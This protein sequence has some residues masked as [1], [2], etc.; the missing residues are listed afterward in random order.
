MKKKTKLRVFTRAGALPPLFRVQATQIVNQ[1]VL[2][3]Q[4]SHLELMSIGKATLIDYVSRLLFFLRWALSRN[5]NWTCCNELDTI[6]VMCYDELYDSDLTV[7]DGSKLLAAMKFIMPVLGLSQSVGFPRAH[8]ALR[9]WHLRRPPV[10]RIPLPWLGL[11]AVLGYL[12]FNSMIP[13]AL[14]LLL[15]FHTYIRPGVCDQLQVSQLVPPHRAAGADFSQWA[16]HLYPSD[17]LRPGKTGGFDEAVLIDQFPWLE[18]FLLLLTRGRNQTDLLWPIAEVIL[19]AQIQQALRYLGLSHLNAS[20]Y[21][22]RHGGASHYLLIHARPLVEVQS[23]GHW[24]SN[25]SLARYGKPARALKE[26]H[27]MPPQVVEYGKAVAENLADVFHQRRLL[28][29]PAGNSTLPL[30][31]S[32]NLPLDADSVTT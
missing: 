22:L 12:C 32:A 31:A 18:P 24:R 13:A 15:Q 16:I 3:K 1:G 4:L 11:T 10:Q 25:L 23:R 7:S 29:P 17:L 21:A 26:L 6:L 14:A 5:V 8:R 2:E 30:A 27:R 19:R 28:V 20:R 9:A